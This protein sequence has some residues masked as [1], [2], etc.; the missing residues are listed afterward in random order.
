[1]VTLIGAMCLVI[2]HLFT[3]FYYGSGFEGPV[4]STVCLIVGLF[5][6]AYIVSQ[7]DLRLWITLM[8][9]RPGALVVVHRSDRY[10]IMAW[11]PSLL[12]FVS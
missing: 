9:S 2:P 1:M 6:M 5:Y 4:D 12:T 7:P 10:L 3:W 8:A 11:T